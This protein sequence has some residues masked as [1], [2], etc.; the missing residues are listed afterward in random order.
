MYAHACTRS[1][2]CGKWV[3]QPTTSPTDRPTD[4]THIADLIGEYQPVPILLCA[5]IDGILLMTIIVQFLLRVH[6]MF[7][8]YEHYKLNCV[9]QLV[10]KK[11]DV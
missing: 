4:R 9:T 3:N 11:K 6:M 2:E 5:T 8:K 10:R 1:Y 7:Q